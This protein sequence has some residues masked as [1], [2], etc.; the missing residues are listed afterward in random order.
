ME[1]CTDKE[2][3]AKWYDH[4]SSHQKDSCHPYSNRTL[5]FSHP[6]QIQGTFYLFFFT[7]THPLG[8]STLSLTCVPL[9]D[10]HQL[11]IIFISKQTLQTWYYRRIPHDLRRNSLS[12]RL[13]LDI[14]R[15]IFSNLVTQCIAYGTCFQILVLPGKW[16]SK[17]SSSLSSMITPCSPCFVQQ[18]Y[19]SIKPFAKM[20]LYRILEKE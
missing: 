9:C 4:C 19:L 2:S 11:S 17:S 10:M 12:G 8:V 15:I 1:D 3:Q 14:S 18:T 7:V 20:W 6:N 16:S 5:C 13:P